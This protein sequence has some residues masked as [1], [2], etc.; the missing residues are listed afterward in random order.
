MANIDKDELKQKAKKKG[1]GF[2]D[3]FKAFILRGNVMD[4]A[5]GVIIGAAFQD[6]VTAL[7][8]SFIQPIINLTGGADI[9]GKIPLGN[10]GQFLDYGAFL[11]AVV[12]FLIM[13]FILFLM[14]KFVNNLGKLTKQEKETVKVKTDETVL[15]EEIRDMMKKQMK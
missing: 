3:E 7:T 2:L 14:L 6:I 13:A 11:T 12:N 15:L 5:I 8:S 10:S 9:Q 4:M 1:I